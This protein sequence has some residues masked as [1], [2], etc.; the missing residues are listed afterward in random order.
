[1]WFQVKFKL[2]TQK[3]DF[4]S[5]PDIR[6]PGC[7]LWKSFQRRKVMSLGQNLCPIHLLIKCIK[8]IQKDQREVGIAW[9]VGLKSRG[10]KINGRFVSPRR[11]D[12]NRSVK[13]LEG[14][15]ARNQ[16]SKSQAFTAREKET[17]NELEFFRIGPEYADQSTQIE[18]VSMCRQLFPLW[19]RY[20]YAWRLH[21]SKTESYISTNLNIRPLQI[22]SYMNTKRKKKILKKDIKKILKRYQQ[23]VK[24]STF[25]PDALLNE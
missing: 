24:K 4:I 13:G 23:I 17:K 8:F 5:L 9:K 3:F 11:K 2:K 25:H 16:A 6:G 7:Y 15:C 12:W 1:M 22:A 19:E 18:M 14:R 10:S 20:S 21:R